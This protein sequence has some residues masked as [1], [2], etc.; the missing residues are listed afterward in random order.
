LP[1]HSTCIIFVEDKRRLGSVKPD[2]TSF[3]RL[4]VALAL[5]YLCHQLI[6]T[7]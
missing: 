1:L 7:A 5:H 2:E 3:P 4:A 6:L